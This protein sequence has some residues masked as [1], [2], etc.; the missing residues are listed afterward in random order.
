MNDIS[1]YPYDLDNCDREPIHRLG[2]IQNF[3]A[4]IAVTGDWNVAHRSANCAALLGLPEPLGVGDRM[5]DHFSPEALEALRTAFGH[6]DEGETVERLFGLDLFG[7]RRLFDVALHRSGGLAIIEIEPHSRDSYSQHLGILRPVMDRL[8]RF[9]E[10]GELT[11]EAARSLKRLLGFDRVMVYRFHP[12]LSGEVIAEA[13]EEHLE[14]F[15]ELR[16]P[17]TDIP[18]QARELYLRNLIRIISDIHAEP[19]PVEPATSLTGEPLDLSLSTLRAVSPIHIEYLKNMGVRASL[20]ISIVIRGKL[21]GL[22]ACHHYSPQVL[23]YSLRT[24]AELFAQLFSLQ[25][26]LAISSAGSRIAER[27]RQLHDRLMT[28]LVGGSSLIENLSALDGVIGQVIPHDGSSALVDGSYRARGSAPTEAEFG[29]IVASLNAASASQ[30]IGSDSLAQLLPGAQGFADRA[31]GALVIPVSRRPRDYIVLWRRELKQVVK[32]AG[33]PEKEIDYGPNGPRLSPRK[34]FE[35]WQ[36]SVSGKSAPWTPEEMAIAEHL[37]VTLLEVI[38]RMNEDQMQERARA[39]AQQELLIAELN[40]RV[41]NILTL[42]RGLISQSRG[43][44][45]SINHFADLIGGRIRALAMAHDNITRQQWSPASL[46][47]LIRTEAEAYLAGKI[48]RVTI[49]GPDVLVAPE[50]YTV[51]ALVIH[52]MITNSAKYGSLCDS[53]GRLSIGTT[54]DEHGD[55]HLAWRE[56][57]GPPVKPPQRRGFGSTIIERSIPFELRGQVDVRHK[58]T[59]LEADFSI[60]ARYIS[61]APQRADAGGQRDRAAQAEPRGSGRHV[62]RHALLVEDSMIIA[63][64][65]EEALLRLGV[66]KVTVASSVTAALDAIRDDA[67]DAAL[68]DFNLGDE[69]SEPIAAELERRQVPYWFVTGYGDAVAQLSSSQARGVLQ[70]PYSPTDLA[71]LLDQLRAKPGD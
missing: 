5:A 41:R 44:G 37:R 9:N 45:I 10:I 61:P 60:P 17:Q 56:E 14:P 71:G 47:E 54:L 68:L 62:V 69:S 1:R 64:D 33:K 50:A 6:A 15:L 27:G 7:K 20:S 32:W 21:W 36:E 51:L 57:G 55:L 16:Y 4:L 2:M 18:Q 24:T 11:H 63:L 30:V 22:F 23:P 42:I 29:A 34:S 28:R 40:H 39:Q 35:A 31:C 49:D 25:L 13:K 48:G 70:K 43:E 46:H 66:D 59:G 52:E 12:D 58:P 26:D 67:P 19:V 53:R 8:Q 3:G 38:L 65:A